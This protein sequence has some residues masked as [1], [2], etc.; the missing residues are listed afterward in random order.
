V[1]CLCSDFS[2]SEHYNHSFSSTCAQRPHDVTQYKVEYVNCDLQYAGVVATQEGVSYHTHV[3]TMQFNIYGHIKTA[4]QCTTV[5]CTLAI[6]GWNVTFGTAKKLGCGPAQSPSRC[7]KC[8]SPPINGQCTNFISFDV[9]LQLP[10]ISKGLSCSI[11]PTYETNTSNLLELC[12][13]LHWVG[14]VKSHYQF[15]LECLLIILV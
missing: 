2:H 1:K 11:S 10:L 4:E 9:A 13:F 6:D 12:I 14:V 8:N 3:Q 5:V 7:T 15:A